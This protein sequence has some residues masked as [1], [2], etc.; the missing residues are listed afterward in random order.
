MDPPQ[1]TILPSN[2]FNTILQRPNASTIST[3]GPSLPVQAPRI[4]TP[5][6]T[7]SQAATTSPSV[8]TTNHNGISADMTDLDR[9][10]GV[11][12]FCTYWFRTGRCDFFNQQGCAYSHDKDAYYA[13]YPLRPAPAAPPVLRERSEEP[14]RNLSSSKWANK[15]LGEVKLTIITKTPLPSPLF[16]GKGASPTKKSWA[17]EKRH[18]AAPAASPAPTLSS[19]KGRVG[20]L[21]RKVVIRGATVNF[22]NTGRWPRGEKVPGATSDE[23]TCLSSEEVEVVK[24]SA[25][26]KLTANENAKAAIDDASLSRPWNKVHKKPVKSTRGKGKGSAKDGKGGREGDLLMPW[27]ES[28]TKVGIESQTGM[29]VDVGDLLGMDDG[30][31]AGSVLELKRRK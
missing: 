15:G 9:P 17:A 7:P 1:A 13:K 2:Q 25:A 21:A 18:Q 28:Q 23:E 12:E 31:V 16:S 27:I 26:P 30:S 8:P 11:K 6:I 24:P 3:P 29:K 20:T 5:P 10:K 14:L 4:L 19:K 22:A